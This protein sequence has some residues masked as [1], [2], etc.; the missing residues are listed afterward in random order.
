MNNDAIHPI[1]VRVQ[2]VLSLVR[3]VELVEQPGDGTGDSNASAEKVSQITITAS[4]LHA[5]Y[6]HC[7]MN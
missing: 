4:P 3:A 5:P 2:P 1:C 7:V 6:A